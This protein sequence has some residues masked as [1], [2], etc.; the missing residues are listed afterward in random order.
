MTDLDTIEKARSILDKTRSISITKDIR[1]EH[2]KE[3]YRITVNGTKAIQWMLT[4]YS[5]MSIRRKEKIRGCLHIWKTNE[6]DPK[7][8]NSPDAKERAGL[9][10]RLRLNGYS[11]DTISMVSNMKRLGKSEEQ[12]G[13]WLDDFNLHPTQSIN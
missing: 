4:I 6:I 5:L 13:K 7:K 2:Y 3:M 1:Q 12:I 10:R 11:E 8:V 9:T